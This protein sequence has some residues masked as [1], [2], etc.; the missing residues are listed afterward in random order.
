MIK[1]NIDTKDFD[2]AMKEYLQFNKRSVADIINAKLYYIAR[3]AT[4]TTQNSRADAIRTEL[5]GP[6]VDY[7]SAPLGA[8]IINSKRGKA[9]LKGL[10]GKA[11]AKELASLIKSRIQSI[12]FVR[13]GWK[14]GIRIIEQYLKSR[15][16]FGYV[17]RNAKGSKADTKTMN[18]KTN[19]AMGTAKVAKI[20]TGP[21]AWGEIVNSAISKAVTDS[22]KLQHVKELG[23]QKAVNQEVASMRV[24]IENKINS[25]AKRFNRW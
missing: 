2:V 11:M 22:Q 4:M 10:R 17:R 20:E 12:N 19:Y 5:N 23:L 6:S 21:R 18:K 15:G 14:N 1:I 3:N 8:I 13:S 16:E 9:G 24:Y 7:P 25:G